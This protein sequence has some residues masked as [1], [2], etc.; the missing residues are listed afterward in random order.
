MRSEIKQYPLSGQRIVVTRSPDQAEELCA[1]LEAL[2]AQCI[3]FP[4]IDFVPL[5]APE[6]AAALTR[7]D[8][9]TWLIFTS[10]NAVR[11]FFER[12]EIGDWR[13]EANLQSPIS[14]LPLPPIAAVGSAT[15]QALAEKG[16]PV[17]F[18]PDEFTGE[19][20]ALGLGDVT[21]QRILLPRARM[22]RPEIVNLLR[23]RGALVDDFALYETVTAV[24]TPEALAELEK[25][26]DI[27]TFTSPSSVRN[28]LEILGTRP[29]RFRKPVRSALVAVIGPSTAI[30]AQKYG[31]RVDIMPQEYTIEGLVTAVE[32]YQTSDFGNQ[33]L[34]KKSDVSPNEGR[35]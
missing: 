4:V 14:N 13:L 8:Q 31:L 30:E 12:L 35:L 17:D 25:G 24:P 7:L 10:A 9:Y 11:F 22:G 19:Q 3:R 2:G 34:L 16:V 32:A 6:L 33:R 29:D 28:F 1:R 5:P 27:L 23:E 21:G 18:V 20:L 26:A 15:Q